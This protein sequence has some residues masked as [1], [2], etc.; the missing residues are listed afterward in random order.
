MKVQCA[1][2][3]IHLLS[4]SSLSNPYCLIPLRNTSISPPFQNS[5][6]L[7]HVLCEI[8]T[9]TLKYIISAE[10]WLVYRQLQCSNYKWQ[11][12]V[13][14]TKQPSGYLSE[15][16]TRKSHTCSLQMISEIY[17]GLTYTVRLLS[18]RTDCAE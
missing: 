11:L 10:S 13:S 3:Q 2:L 7:H 4:I 5:K 1:F 12:H 18:F 16:Y 9:V 15:K 14:A 8:P 17:F 6:Q